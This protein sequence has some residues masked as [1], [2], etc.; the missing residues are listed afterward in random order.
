MFTPNALALQINLLFFHNDGYICSGI[1]FIPPSTI[2]NLPRVA[3]CKKKQNLYLDF[4]VLF[5]VVFSFFP[6]AKQVV[7]GLQNRSRNHRTVF[8][9]GYSTCRSAIFF[10]CSVGFR[11]V[12]AVEWV[13]WRD[14]S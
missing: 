7:F 4:L 2:A 8:N 11:E 10:L 12:E 6:Q 5:F 3:V 9:L 14:W 1:C 13:S